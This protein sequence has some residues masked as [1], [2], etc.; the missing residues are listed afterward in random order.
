M[1]WWIKYL[2]MDGEGDGSA[3]GGGGTGDGGTGDG[4]GGTGDAGTGDGKGGTGD[5]KGGTGDGTPPQRWYAD[6]WREKLAKGNDAAM[7]VLKRYNT[8]EDW[9]NAGLALRQKIGSGELRA[10]LPKD[11]T[12]EQKAEWRAANGIPPSPDKYELK[13]PEGLVVGEGDKPQIDAFLGVAHAAELRPDQV[14]AAI[15]WFYQNQAKQTE[16]RLEQDATL[17]EDTRNALAVEWQGDYKPNMNLLKNFIGTLPQDVRELFERGRLAN[18][19][20]ILAN[21]HMVKALTGWARQLADTGTILPPGMGDAASVDTRIT[22]IEAEMKK[23][24][25]GQYYGG[26]KETVD[27]VTDTKMAHEYRKLLAIRDRAKQQA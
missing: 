23:G 21:Q 12:D 9:T 6:D 19:D 13:L 1:S 2:K 10:V 18:G 11:A 22:E 3:G 20:P 25:K 7:N 24:K 5:G 16:T 15:G 8:L 17:A 27:G 4:K 26:P 14:N